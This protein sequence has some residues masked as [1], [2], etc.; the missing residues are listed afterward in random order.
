MM[1]EL[2]ARLDNVIPAISNVL[3]I[4]G[5]PGLSIGVFHHGEVIYTKHFGQRDIARPEP[6]DDETI[7]YTASICKIL[8]M[9]VVGSLVAEGLLN[10]DAPIREYLPELQQRNDELGR[11]ATLRDI[12]SNRTGLPL[13]NFFWGQMHT[14]ALLHKSK[15]IQLS[16]NLDSIKPFRSAFHYST[17]NYVLVHLIVEKVTG[18]L[19]GQVAE[20]RIFKPLGL[21]SLTYETP[22]S[23]NMTAP[24]A[25]LNNGTA[26][27]TERNIY[28]SESGLAACHGG[29]GSLKDLLSVYAA[30]VVAYVHQRDNNVDSTPNSPFKQLRIIFEPHIALD[31]TDNSSSQAYCL[32]LYRTKLPGI[33]S[34]ASLNYPLLHKKIPAFGAGV[35]GTEV[36]HHTGNIPGYFNSMF[37]IPETQSGVVCLSNALPLMDPTDFAA[38]LMLGALLNQPS[39]DYAPL[40]KAAAKAQLGWY[41]LKSTY[42]AQKKTNRPPS[43]PLSEYAGTYWYKGKDFFKLVLTH[44]EHG[45]CL[46]VQGSAITTY[47][48]KPWDADTFFWPA[49]RDREVGHLGMFPFPWPT[50]HLIGFEVKD[51]KTKTLRWQHDMLAKTFE[52]VKEADGQ[53]AKL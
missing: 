44:A 29:K 32:G 2:L 41:Y 21:S 48:I 8:S 43:L 26:V 20:E 5:S 39:I 9:C 34:C 28:D 14:D 22:S 13:A 35:A 45:L 42:L 31:S 16:A 11:E 4:S 24:H 7:Y 46:S 36:F 37:L 19:F 3:N 23:D 51:G 52:F 53:T 47:D 15:Y 10:W 50:T 38:Q 17:W 49:D 33:L 30:L 40:A 18:K 1:E 12:A 27:K 6:P 25:V